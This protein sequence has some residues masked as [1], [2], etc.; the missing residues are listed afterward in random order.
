MAHPTQQI[1]LGTKE[2][3]WLKRHFVLSA[4]N[5]ATHKHIIGLTGQGK[6]KLLASM[7]AQL[8]TSGTP[9][10]LID[11]H[12]DLASDVLGMLHDAGYFNQANPKVKYVDFSRTDRFIPWNV[13]KQPYEPHQVAENIVEVC[14]RAWKALGQGAAPQFENILLA[15]S[16]VLICNHLPITELPRLI[17]NKGYRDRLLV[18]V[19]DP[20][21]VD[22]FHERM[23]KWTGKE[24]TDNVESTLRR[25]FLLT[26]SP[27]LKYTLGQA[28]NVLD[29]RSIMDSG[30]SM[31]FDL[32]RLSEPVQRFIGCLLTVGFEV[33]S[34]SRADMSLDKRTQYHLF[35]DEF[36][37]FSAQSEESLSRILSL[38]RKY[39]LF[40][41]MAHQTWSQVSERLQGALQNC[42]TISF[43]LG[44]SDAEWMARQ[45]IE[46]KPEE[47]KQA[48]LAEHTQTGFTPL[49]EQFEELIEEL[50]D[51][52]KR[53]CFVKLPEHPRI[54]K[55]WK[56]PKLY[57][58]KTLTLPR[59]QADVRA[60]KERFAVELMQRAEYVR[61]TVETPIYEKKIPRR[62]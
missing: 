6:S 10:A 61:E 40:L 3:F 21:V 56:K 60:L 31:I 27:T 32:G 48:E 25:V 46:Y 45:L 42:L 33:A 52:H 57:K 14:L 41:V 38:A 55:Y 49:T 20:Q 2:P 28:E 29:F 18:Q 36:S 54:L 9:A 51:L 1:R 26:F 50:T 11:P 17:T 47:V 22:F 35:M 12:S 23:D 24:Q 16:Y 4:A 7:Y 53:V 8:V 39:G 19:D 30:M 62:Y 44:R 43:K 59:I 5:I 15:S 37:M 13:L 58:V 34:L